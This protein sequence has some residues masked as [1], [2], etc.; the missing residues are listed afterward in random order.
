MHVTCLNNAPVMN[1][2]GTL[3][4]RQLQGHRLAGKEEG[5]IMLDIGWFLQGVPPSRLSCSTEDHQISYDSAT[6]GTESMQAIREVRQ[7][8]AHHMTWSRQ[9]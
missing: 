9:T 6:Q 5:P 2:L 4:G 8:I 7:Y 1:M 3:P